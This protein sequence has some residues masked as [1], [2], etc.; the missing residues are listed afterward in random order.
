[1]AHSDHQLLINSKSYLYALILAGTLALALLFQG[2]LISACG[3]GVLCA[4]LIVNQWQSKNR[5]AD[6]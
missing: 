5:N 3:I 6:K 2:Q 1:M 4:L